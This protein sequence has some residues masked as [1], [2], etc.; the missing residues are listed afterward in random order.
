M[1]LAVE[2]EHHYEPNMMLFLRAVPHEP[3]LAPTVHSSI[4]GS[5]H[6][7]HRPR[8]RGSRLLEWGRVISGRRPVGHFPD[9]SQ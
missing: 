1:F 4:G 5:A 8:K 6:L 3:A 2:A 9:T 7:G